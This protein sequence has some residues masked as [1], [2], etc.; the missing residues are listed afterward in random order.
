MRLFWK[1]AK[2]H[3]V[4]VAVSKSVRIPNRFEHDSV[5]DVV[6]FPTGS[7]TT[8]TVRVA[9]SHHFHSEN[10]IAYEFGYRFQPTKSLS[11]DI[12]TFYNV[13]DDLRTTENVTPFID[14]VNSTNTI[15]P[16]IFDNKMDGE[17]FGLEILTTWNV[18]DSW[19]LTAGYT[20]LEM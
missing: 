17:T 14:P 11:V 19:K 13:Y 5:N 20:F 6:T 4:W 1:P 3:A 7:V 18:T 9:D 12:A 10:L 8:G 2:R 15:I 16:I